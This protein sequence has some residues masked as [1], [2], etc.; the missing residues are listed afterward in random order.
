[1]GLISLIIAFE[2]TFFFM[3]QVIVGSDKRGTGMHAFSVVIFVLAMRK[4]V[5]CILTN[6]NKRTWEIIFGLAGFLA[7]YLATGMIYRTVDLEY[8]GYLLAFGVRCIPA[9]FCAIVIADNASYFNQMQKWLQVLVLIYTIGVSI[10]VFTA[11]DDI[12]L[13]E[14]FTVGINYQEISYSAAFAFNIDLYLV[15]FWNNI[16]KF[17]LL[18]S[19][20]WR[21]VNAGI[22]IL[23]LYCM[24]SGGGRGAIVDI[25]AVTVFLLYVKRGFKLNVGFLLGGVIFIAFVFIY[26]CFRSKN[27][28][29]RS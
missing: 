28:R 20:F 25:I 26:I 13:K 18:R 14:K 27:G 19:S 23:L 10:A 6:N 8:R 3:L 17:R 9:V 5:S 7:L 2:Y 15:M 24:V 11:T 22:L 16:H 21:R 1:M 4:A 12:H 29:C